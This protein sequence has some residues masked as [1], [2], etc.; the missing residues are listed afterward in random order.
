M[1]NTPQ[2][3]F[4]Q[5]NNNDYYD[6]EEMKQIDF[7][8]LAEVTWHDERLNESDLVYVL[9]N[10]FPSNDFVLGMIV[11]LIISLISTL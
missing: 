6:K 7:K 1:K 9:K 4:L 11:A 2:K 8:E 3:I 5:V 10:R